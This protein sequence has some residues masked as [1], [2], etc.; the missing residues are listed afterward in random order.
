MAGAGCL[1]N[2]ELSNSSLW[3]RSGGARCRRALEIKFRGEP[4]V[5]ATSRGESPLFDKVSNS[6]TNPNSQKSNGGAMKI[7][8]GIGALILPFILVITGAGP[9][10]LLQMLSAVLIH[11]M[12]HGA[13]AIILKEKIKELTVEPFGARIAL[14]GSMSYS[15]ELII[16]L[17]GPSASLLLFA[18]LTA[19]GR[20]GYGADYSLFLGI[21]NL[22]PVRT[23][24]GGR[25]L[26]CL[27]SYFFGE[28]VGNSVIGI[29]SAVCI[30]SIWIFSVYLLLHNGV[31]F[32]LFVFSL[33]LTLA[34]LK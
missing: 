33:I 7:R 24:D 6:L 18:L 4:P 29:C 17:S 3:W 31:G 12:G 14:G 26:N 20:A 27:L 28:A 9:I 15:H 8:I 25:G 21:I 1:L 5:A 10:M 13:A 34:A 22:L 23:L 16:A 2:G 19:A 11:E 30:F 32:G